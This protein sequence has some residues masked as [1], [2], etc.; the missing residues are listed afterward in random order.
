MKRKTWILIT[1]IC[2]L[3]GAA[4]QAAEVVLDDIAEGIVKVSGY[5]QAAGEQ[6][7]LVVLNPGAEL[8]EA[9]NDA[10]LSQY[11]DAVPVAEDGSYSAK[12]S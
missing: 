5:G 7:N 6:V 10:A 2:I 3:H 1:L 9:G 12:S 8:G 11:V 4:A